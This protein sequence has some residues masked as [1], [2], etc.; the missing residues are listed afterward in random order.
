MRIA[1]PHA[2]QVLRVD[3]ATVRDAVLPIAGEDVVVAAQCTNR[4]DLGRL[5]AEQRWPKPQFALALQCCRFNVDAADDDHVFVK[6]E[7]L[8][9]GDVRDPGVKVRTAP[10]F[11]VGTDQLD[12][13]L[14]TKEFRHPGSR[15]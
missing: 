7:K 2:K 13:V 1:T 15:F 5:L 3:P 9:L 12:E 4:A 14:I 11:A 6:V 8:G 10:P